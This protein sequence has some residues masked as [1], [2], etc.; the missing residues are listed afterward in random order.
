[1]PLRGQVFTVDVGGGITPRVRSDRPISCPGRAVDLPGP[2]GLRVWFCSL[3][4]IGDAHH[5]HSR[6]PESNPA[7]LVEDD[8]GPHSISYPRPILNRS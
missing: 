2:S 5:F 1:M 8:T 3:A 6:N 7:R 4:G